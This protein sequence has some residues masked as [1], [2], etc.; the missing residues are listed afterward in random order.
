M[1]VITGIDK[2]TFERVVA[3]AHGNTMMLDI[4]Q[5]KLRNDKTREKRVNIVQHKKAR[6]GT[7]EENTIAK[8]AVNAI[9][10]TSNMLAFD[11]GRGLS[12]YIYYNMIT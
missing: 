1:I 8:C 7:E 2:N 10:A 9:L 12:E 3:S 4:I 6:I 5:T 11:V